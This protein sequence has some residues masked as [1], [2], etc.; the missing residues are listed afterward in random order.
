MRSS[1]DL[2]IIG[3]GSAGLAGAAFA[4]KIGL[5]VALV[6]AAR[7]GG[8]CTWTGCVPSKALLHAAAAGRAARIGAGGVPGRDAPIDFAGVR[9]FVHAARERVYALET[10][11]ELERQGIDVLIGQPAF[12]DGRALEVDGRAVR[13]RR[14]L[15]CTGAVP[16]VPL[17]PGLVGGPY[18]TNHTVFDELTVL[19]E[20]LI[21][22]G[23]GPVGVEFAQAF[24]R[25][26]SRVTLIGRNRRLLPA[27]DDEASE[28]LARVLR[29]EGITV[30][31]GMEVDGVEHG[32]I[33][34]V[35]AG[36]QRH[37]CDALLVAVGRRPN[38]EGMG[39]ERAGV[40]I[41]EKGITVNEKLRTS[42]PHIYA[43]GDVTGSFQFTHYAG[44]QA[45]MAVRNMFLPGSTRALLPSVPWAVF[46][47]P[48]VAQVGLTEREARANGEKY[49][50]HRFPIARNDRAQ[51]TGEVHGS[52]KFVLRRN[53]TILGA[54]IVGTAAGEMINEITLAIDNKIAFDK[55]C[56]SIHIY[57]SYGFALQLG[58]ADAL[59]HD[60][61][62]GIKGLVIRALA[63]LAR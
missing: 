3:A 27:A 63:R 31:L 53:G 23:G 60:L 62:H 35:M 4:R 46:T 33:T 57:P 59:Y 10:P 40:E 11:E 34:T 51:T 32:V 38:V 14:F 58:S 25:L 7:V 15:L 61:S 52:M 54:T 2:I 26:G 13:A 56:R 49:E 5:R 41:G 50:V 36:G 19:P 6:E 1:Y 37:E 55:L 30:H 12:R 22:L 16:V 48:E 42:H 47:D 28:L 9:A 45:V 29:D 17:I 21:V 24:R 8:D 44:W 43:A 18:L 20:H 39:L